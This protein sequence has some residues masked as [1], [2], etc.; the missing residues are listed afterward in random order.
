[1]GKFITPECTYEG[2]WVNGRKEGKGKLTFPESVSSVFFVFAKCSA[3]ATPLLDNG[4]TV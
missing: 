2:E 1:M 3:V 4:R